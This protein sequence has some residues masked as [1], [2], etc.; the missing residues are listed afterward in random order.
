VGYKDPKFDPWVGY[1][2]EG[3]QI[4]PNSYTN[5][6]SK[7]YGH[8]GALTLQSAVSLGRGRHCVRTLCKLARQYIHNRTV[9]PINPYGKWCNSLLI[10]EDLAAD[11]NL[12]LQEIGNHITAEKLVLYLSQPEVMEKHGITKQISVSTARCYLHALGY[13]FSHPK[14]GQY[15]DGHERQDIVFERDKKYIPAIKKLEAQMQHWDRDGRT[16]FG[17][18]PAGKRVIVWYQDES[19]FYAH[20][21]KR[22][23]WHH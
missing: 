7:T 1:H 5:T 18:P 17:P 11:I 16:E 10:N 6:R 12:H 20:D 8:W 15:S 13:R 3:M 4:F 19:I 9:L 21:R 23:N 22:K 2:L 14:T